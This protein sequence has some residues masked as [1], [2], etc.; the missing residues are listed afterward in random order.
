V[1]S[2][3]LNVGTLARVT[4]DGVVDRTVDVPVRYPSDVAFGGPALDRLFVV[5]IALDL[6]GGEPGKAAGQLL[7]LD[8]VGIGRPAPRVRL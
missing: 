4:L 6:G 3:V 1:W 7:A 2:C 8:G 5:S